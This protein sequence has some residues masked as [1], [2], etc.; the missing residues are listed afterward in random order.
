MYCFDVP[1]LAVV[2]DDCDDSVGGSREVP[3]E[4]R[5]GEDGVWM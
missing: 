4:E 5:E 1:A 2:S 3:A